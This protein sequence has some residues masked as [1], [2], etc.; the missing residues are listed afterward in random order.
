M[1]E[2]GERW[3]SVVCT[4]TP[5]T[6]ANLHRLGTESKGKTERHGPPEPSLR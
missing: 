5:T 3:E 4:D 6:K 1:R 2:M